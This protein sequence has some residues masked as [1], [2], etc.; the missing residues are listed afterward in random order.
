MEGFVNNKLKIHK[1]FIF[2]TLILLILSGCKIQT[3]NFSSDKTPQT[4]M[5]SKKPEKEAN[6]DS[7][8]VGLTPEKV[9]KIVGLPISSVAFSTDEDSDTCSYSVKDS[10][11]V[12]N[13]TTVPLDVM[14]KDIY[15][16]AC[17]ETH[18]SQQY[19]FRYENPSKEI[20]WS[21]TLSSVLWRTGGTVVQVSLVNTLHPSSLPTS[22]TTVAY[23]VTTKLAHA[24]LPLLDTG[25]L[26]V[27]E[28]NMPVKIFPSVKEGASWCQFYWDL[29]TTKWVY[30]SNE[31][32]Q[33]KRLMKEAK[34]TRNTKVAVA[35][36]KIPSDSTI[37]SE[38]QLATLEKDLDNVFAQDCG[39]TPFSEIKQSIGRPVL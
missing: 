3:Q 12:I 30:D 35:G 33:L 31:I 13:I 32:H 18:M 15:Y 11:Y 7:Q 25:S 19:L 26:P 6:L 17:K 10:H 38:Q 4:T 29:V 27:L 34:D 24:V 28:E 1:N 39:G 9:T 14:G 37:I 2:I 8:C 36:E 20:C 21:D 22:D 23:D 5:P 16:R